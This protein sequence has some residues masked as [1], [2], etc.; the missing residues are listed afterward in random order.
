MTW[1]LRHSRRNKVLKSM[2]PPKVVKKPPFRQ[3][4]QNLPTIF[5]FGPREMETS[6]FTANC[7]KFAQFTNQRSESH[8]ISAINTNF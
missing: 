5:L 7:T 2:Y 3:I 8:E 1:N 6:N 4:M